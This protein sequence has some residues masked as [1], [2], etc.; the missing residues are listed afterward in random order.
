MRPEE[1]AYL[2]AATAVIAARLAK[3]QPGVRFSLSNLILGAALA[4]AS[5]ALGT[6]LAEWKPGKRPKRK[7]GR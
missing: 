5:R 2:E 7:D 3:D 1:L 4:E 6:A